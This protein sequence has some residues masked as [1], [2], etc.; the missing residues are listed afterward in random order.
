M[1]KLRD[2][3]VSDLLLRN[4]SPKTLQAYTWAMFHF[5]KHFR[6]SPDLMGESEIR[7]FLLYLVEG[8]K[9]SPSL[10]KMFTAGIKFFY[11]VTLNRP[12][13][14]ER[15]PY[16]KIPKTLPDV[17]TQEEVAAIINAVES[18]KYRAIIATTYAA[19]L[20]IAETCRL[21]AR[22]DIDS[23]R[24]VI[25]VRAGKGAKDRYVMFGERLLI[26]LREYWTQ[27]RPK[28]L[29]LFPGQDPDH[30]ISP[31]SVY[32]VFK[33]ALKKTVIT[34]HVTLHTLRHSCATHLT[35]AHTDIRLIQVLLG[36]GSI[37]T[38]SRYT[39]VSAELIG[40]IKSPFE[41]LSLE[42]NSRT[43]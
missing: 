24:M 25:H 15:I 31:D 11:R 1:G 43:T 17:L 28:G 35:E 39:H 7:E 29:Y 23:N 19:G 16:P 9:A 3:M 10:R 34:K 22:G 42:K 4:Y 12:E 37:R 26:L 32:Q 21:Y 5:V 36:H 38:T 18:V 33:K 13:A 8:R 30:P 20:R 6:R 27:T 40:R 14:V 41:S 2:Q